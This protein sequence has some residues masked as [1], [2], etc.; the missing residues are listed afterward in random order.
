MK[1]KLKNDGFKVKQIKIFGDIEKAIKKIKK[2]IPHQKKSA[3]IFGGEVTINVKGGGMGGR[4]QELVLRILSQGLISK[5][6]IIGAI[7]TDG[8][9]GNTKYA[10]VISESKTNFSDMENYLKRNDSN[11][12]FKK[13]GGLIMT[14]PTRTNLMDVGVILRQ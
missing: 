11:S 13:H 4:C 12:F 5:D 1:R 3:L 7:G 8:I 2:N 6:H 14:G 9:D 10:G